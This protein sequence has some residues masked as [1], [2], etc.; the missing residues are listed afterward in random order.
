VNL[1]S[2][3]QSIERAVQDLSAQFPQVL[4]SHIEHIVAEVRAEYTDSR[5]RDFVPLFVERSARQRLSG[6]S[7]VLSD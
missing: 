3:Q 4:R 2:E 5:I 1:P 6:L 7:A